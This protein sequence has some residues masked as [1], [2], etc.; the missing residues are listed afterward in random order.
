MLYAS[1]NRKITPV[2]FGEAV[3]S[4]LAEDGGLFLPASIPELETS[5]VSNLRSLGLHEISYEVAHPFLAGEIP[6]KDLRQIIEDSFDF[7]VP[8]VSLENETYSLELFHGPTLAFK[9]F[10]ARFMARV[11]S[12]FNRNADRPLTILV[13]TSGDTG[14]AVAHG[15]FGIEG[16]SVV[17]LYPQGKVSRLQEMQMTTLGGNVTALEVQGTFDDCQRLVKEAFQDNT[18]RPKRRLSSA[19]SINI[20]RLIPQSFYYFYA[21]SQLREASLPVV[22]SVPS[23]NFGNLTAGVLAKRMGLPISLFIAATNVNDIVPEYLESGLFE[24]RPSIRT[25]STAMDVGNPSNFVRLLAIYGS[26]EK[27]REEILGASFTDNQT[28]VAMADVYKQY[29]YI[30]DP[31]GAIG[32]LGLKK[33]GNARNVQGIFLETAH[34]AKFRETV[35]QAIGHEIPLPPALAECLNRTKQTTVIPPRFEELKAVLI[36]G[37]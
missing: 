14:S 28:R 36:S 31:H 4:G 16:I 9:D 27:M 7:K 1:T 21:M 26:V 32:Y 19:N 6:D 8:L 23:G 29:G 33:V 12:Y 25:I 10:G 2:T 3:L 17:L 18:L 13:A 11:L 22:F 37:L 24:P 30:L 20:A 15:F 35:A 5:F 34:P